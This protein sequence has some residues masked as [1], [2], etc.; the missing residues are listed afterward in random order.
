MLG[1]LEEVQDLK[2][3]LQELK[4]VPPAAVP[5]SQIEIEELTTDNE[6][7]TTDNDQLSDELADLEESILDLVPFGRLIEAYGASPL[8]GKVCGEVYDK[9]TLKQNGI[10]ASLK[11]HQSE[12]EEILN[13]TLSLDND[14]Y[15][16]REM[17]KIL[18]ELGY[19]WDHKQI[20]KVEKYWVINPKI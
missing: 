6:E 8:D 15:P 17:N 3:Q 5:Q 13:I 12:I 11:T 19:K 20:S 7:L 9:E 18:K 10:F 2:S 14:K 16:V 1:L 4:S